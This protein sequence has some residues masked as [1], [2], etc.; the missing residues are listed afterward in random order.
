MR[1]QGGS[2]LPLSGWGGVFTEAATEEDEVVEAVVE[3]VV[4]DADV[5]KPSSKAKNRNLNMM[6][7]SGS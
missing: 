2:I 7:G 4:E 3:V 1:R 5:G 6:L